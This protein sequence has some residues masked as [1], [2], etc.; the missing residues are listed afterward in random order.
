M[1]RDEII[2]FAYSASGSSVAMLNL[3]VKVD[4]ETISKRI[5]T[6]KMFNQQQNI[7]SNKYI[8]VLVTR[9]KRS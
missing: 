9:L 5:L 6:Q 3:L 7:L 1:E 2:L 4:M 8:R